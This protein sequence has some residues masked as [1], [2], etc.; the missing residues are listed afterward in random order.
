MK[1]KSLIVALTFATLGLISLLIFMSQAHTEATGGD[2]IPILIVTKE[3]KRGAI[4]AEDQI[5]IREIPQAYVEPRMIKATERAKVLGIKTEVALVPQQTL[6]WGD[7]AVNGYDT[8]LVSRL[9]PV[10][11]RAFSVQIRQEFMNARLIRPGD[12]IDVLGV[13][14]EEHETSS[15]ILLQK[16]LVLAVNDSTSPI[17]LS[18][19]SGMQLTLSVSLQEAQVLALALQRGALAPAIRSGI[20]TDITHNSSNIK[21]VIPHE[22]KW[23]APTAVAGPAGPTRL[24]GVGKHAH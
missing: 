10:G 24:P 20:D 11:S 5:G 22:E 13:V 21:R 3:V 23:K 4:V 6:T 12:F 2:K 18:L 8:H 17:E 1:L 9:V 15:A 16:I 14:K 19:G 7:L